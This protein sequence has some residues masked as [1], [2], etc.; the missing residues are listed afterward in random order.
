[1]LMCSGIALAAICGW[2]RDSP[3][4]YPRSRRATSI[5]CWLP[6]RATLVSRALFHDSLGPVP[7]RDKWAP[8]G[9]PGLSGFS[10]RKVEEAN[11]LVRFALSAME[12]A[13]RCSTKKVGA[14]LE[15]PEYL[16]D[17]PCGAPASLWQL[18]EARSLAD[19]RLTRGAIFQCE[20]G[21][22]DFSKPTGI[23]TNIDTLVSDPGFYAGWPC[24]A[25][26]GLNNAYTGPLP[27]KCRH[28]GCAA[29]F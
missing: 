10:L 2:I 11:S 29:P 1:M 7:L 12:A 21:S 13:G 16:W 23:L 8:W 18:P 20:W 9:R 4:C 15:F 5:W 28:K 26:T 17:A 19:L 3:S 25:P 22:T 14:W 6:L 27:S 24:F